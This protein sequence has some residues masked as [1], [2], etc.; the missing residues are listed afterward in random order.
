MSP[1]SG[2]GSQE[3]GQGSCGPCSGC[4]PLNEEAYFS[5]LLQK[6]KFSFFAW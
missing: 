1:E 2:V 3:D 5:S 4:N 6:G